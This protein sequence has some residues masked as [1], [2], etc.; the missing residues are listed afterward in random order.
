MIAAYIILGITLIGL[1]AW[2][3]WKYYYYV[4]QTELKFA[5][6]FFV[7]NIKDMKFEDIQTIKKI[8]YGY[9]NLSFYVQLKDGK[10]YQLRF[11]RNNEIVDRKN[12]R[13][14]INLI[15]EQNDYLYYDQYGNFIKK[16]ISGKTITVKEVNDEYLMKL[17]TKINEFH[18]IKVSDD[19]ILK[20]NY[21]NVLETK[22][23]SKKYLDLYA[24]SLSK[25][26]LNDLVLSHNDL[27][28]D[29]IIVNDKNE[30]IFIDFEWTRMNVPNWDII[31][32]CRE[33]SFNIEKIKN[34]ARL[35]NIPL[36]DF[37]GLYYI[38]L[39][40][41]YNWTFENSF[42]FK[43]FKYRLEVRKQVNKIYRYLLKQINT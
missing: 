39:C 23:L 19:L 38:S 1:L 11:A 22:R 12:E 24:S 21:N 43:I 15:H 9:T 31:N 32:F 27:N 37:L 33:S 8:H 5:K 10:E 20:H 14:V 25:L 30:L 41:A 36:V 3:I 42:S 6:T 4:P 16:W 35:Y 13:K 34:V 29:N 26:N 18:N 40:F 7:K 2:W 28:V 17:Q